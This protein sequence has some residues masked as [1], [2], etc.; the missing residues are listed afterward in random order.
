MFEFLSIVIFAEGGLSFQAFFR[1]AWKKYPE[2]PVDPVKKRKNIIESI[3]INKTQ[4]L[5]I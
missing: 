1:K 2:N 4:M 5:M 3:P